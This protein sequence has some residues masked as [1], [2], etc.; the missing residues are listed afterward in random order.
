MF[1][2]YR[3]LFLFLIPVILNVVFLLRAKQNFSW[4]DEGE[5]RDFNWWEASISLLLFVLVVSVFWRWGRDRRINNFNEQIGGYVTAM[6]AQDGSHEEPYDCN[7]TTDKDGNRQCSTC[8]ETVYHR[9]FFVDNDT[10]D[11]W[12]GNHWYD[13]VDKPC[14]TCEPYHI[15]QYYLNAYIGKPLS[16]D[17]SYSN[18]IAAINDDLYRN[19]YNGLADGVPDIC[20]ETSDIRTS[21][22]DVIKAIPLGFD[23]TSALRAAVY[24]WNFAPHA[25]DAT[26]M[27][28]QDYATIP[29]YMDTQFGWLG[30]NVQADTHVYVVN[31]ANIT[32]A[33]LCLAKWKGGAKNSIYVFIFGT[34]NDDQSDFRPSDVYVGVGVDG[35][36]QN[37]G[38]KN[39]NQNANNYHMKFDIRNQLLDYFQ[40]GGTLDRESVLGIIFTNVKD[41]FVRQEMAGF[42][43]L[44]EQ[45]QP[46]NGWIFGMAIVLLILDTIQH[47]LW[48]NNDM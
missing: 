42:K 8:Y 43:A 29:L 22:T 39:Q 44:K 11:W 19:T 3:V 2:D 46:T 4:R 9:E 30:K 18:Y 1:H 23:K 36:K 48:A 21:D 35:A 5:S 13:R 20:P 32:Y 16:L 40:A 26:Y 10:G 37:T 7:C 28:A 33:D 17:H 24:G 12:K 31:S 45:V 38:L 25:G 6:H 47:F 41:E 27:P 14:S 15:P 34:P